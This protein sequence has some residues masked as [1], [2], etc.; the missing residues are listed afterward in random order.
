MVRYWDPSALVPLLVR[1]A[2]T[3]AVH[4]ELQ[5]QPGILTWWGSAVEC[6]SALARLDREGGLLGP[7]ADTA[8][9]RYRLL[10]QRWAEVGPSEPVRQTAL[11]LL[12]THPLRAADALQLAAA[13]A[14]S[15]GV[16]TSLP[17][18]TLDLRLAEAADKEGFPIVV[19][20]GVG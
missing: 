5:Q 11:R 3:Q 13:I 20:G 7:A 12:R 8:R 17:F 2:R 19:P 4:L 14:A 9:V 18:V 10:A 6:A 16:T 15:E 1:Q